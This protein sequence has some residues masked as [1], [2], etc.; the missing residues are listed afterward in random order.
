MDTSKPP[1]RRLS[2]FFSLVI[3]PGQSA[4]DKTHKSSSQQQQSQDVHGTTCKHDSRLRR[5]GQGIRRWRHGR[6]KG[7]GAHEGFFYQ[8]TKADTTLTHSSSS[9]GSISVHDQEHLTKQSDGV[10][11][12]GSASA[13]QEEVGKITIDEVILGEAGTQQQAIIPSSKLDA[14]V[15]GATPPQKNGPNEDKFKKDDTNEEEI[16]C[17]AETD[18]AIV[19]KA[20][21][22]ADND[23]VADEETALDA[24]TPI[25]TPQSVYIRERKEAKR[26]ANGLFVSSPAANN[27]SN[28]LI[29]WTDASMRMTQKNGN[30]GGTSVARQQDGRWKV[31]YAHVVGVNEISILEALAILMA[32]KMAIHNCRGTESVFVLSDGATCLTWLAKV[33]ALF[34]ANEQANRELQ[35]SKCYARA[36]VSFSQN[37]GFYKLDKY[38]GNDLQAVVCL[39]ILEAYSKLRQLGAIVE[40]H[41]VPGHSKVI[42][43]VIADMWAFNACLWF[44]EVSIYVQDGEARVIPLQPLDIPEPWR[45]NCSRLSSKRP[46]VGSLSQILEGVKH[47]Q[48][49]LRV[50][51]TS[52]PRTPAAAPKEIEDSKGQGKPKPK[53][54]G[55]KCSACKQRGHTKKECKSSAPCALCQKAG[56]KEKICQLK[57]ICNLC[58]EKGH[59]RARC[60]KNKKSKAVAEAEGVGSEQTRPSPSLSLTIPETSLVVGLLHPTLMSKPLHGARS[61]CMLVGRV[62]LDLKLR[63]SVAVQDVTEGQL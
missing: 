38:P 27:F 39:Q 3:H 8:H 17:S 11:G 1:K 21:S 30:R 41:W 42:G 31:E 60:Q 54:S 15:V 29:F 36:M 44:V 50:G 16:A 58:G 45:V 62:G 51:S 53:K 34:R 52:F 63:P 49:V 35:E 28:K 12:S 6:K 20:P 23:V 61:T 55:P 56:H 26:F 57:V 7:D 59:K 19:E 47:S 48:Y 14:P 24:P 33:L 40:F 10:V 25:S 22:P 9:Q 4:K 37:F 5:L 43:N 2:S 13:K 32:L 18:L 46:A